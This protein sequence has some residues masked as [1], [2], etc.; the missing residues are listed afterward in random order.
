MSSSEAAPANWRPDAQVVMNKIRPII[1]RVEAERI[2]AIEK[3]A[4]TV[5]W[6]TGVFVTGVLVVLVGLAS[7]VG[8]GIAAL[9]VV[10]IFGIAAIISYFVIHGGATKAYRD[11]YKREVLQGAVREAVPGMDYQPVSMVPEASFTRGGLF[12]SRIDRYSG[13]DCFSGKVGA[14]NLIFSELHVERKDT[15]T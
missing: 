13:E 12:K 9:V 15:S 5:R 14:T 1:D 3:K 2:L 11:T 7:G 6:A 10:G 4:K 8:S